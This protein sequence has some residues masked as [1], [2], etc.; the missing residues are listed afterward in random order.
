VTDVPGDHP[1]FRDAVELARAQWGVVSVRQLRGLGAAEGAAR[2]WL[3]AGR[4]IRLHRGVYAVGHDALQP[5]GRWLAAVLACGAGAALSHATAAAHLDL[6]ALAS[7]LVDVIVPSPRRS[8]KGIRV[9]CPRHLEPGDVIEHAGIPT[10]SPTRTLID[11]AEVLSLPALERVAA[12]AEHRQ[13]LDH[14]RLARARSRKLRVIFGAG[15]PPRTRSGDESRFLA[16]VVAAQLPAPEANVWLSHGGGEEWQADLL[17]RTQCVIVEIDDDRH[18]TRHAF[19]LDRQKDAIRQADGYAT[20][21]F[22]RRQ[23]REDLSA[24]VSLVASTLTARRSVG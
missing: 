9:H 3:R 24:C 5:Q 10:T 21:R 23:L 1:T 11:L 13:L 19:E 4:L 7:R 14:A 18:R 6:R 16:A 22:T 12:E 20:L 8:R 2:E 17:W 15:P